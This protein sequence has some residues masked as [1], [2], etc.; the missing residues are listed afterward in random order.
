MSNLPAMR[1]PRRTL[2]V[3][4]AAA[5]VLAGCGTEESPTVGSA[6]E[7]TPTSQSPASEPTASD[8]PSSIT[9]NAPIYF[10][11]KTGGG[12][13]LFREFHEVRGITLTEAARLVD[14]GTPQDPDYRTLWPGGTVVTAVP[15]GPF[16]TVTLN[17]DAFTEAPDGMSPKEADL[18]IQQMVWTLQGVEQNTHRVRFVRPK[19]TSAPATPATPGATVA[20]DTLFGIDISKPFPA[21]DW[22]TTLALVNVTLPTDGASVTGDILE[23]EGLASSFEGNVPWQILREDD[24]VLS[25]F[26]TADGWMEKLYPWSASIDVSKLEP[27][28]YTFVASTDDPSDGESSVKVSNDSKEFTLN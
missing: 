23:A 28:D 6:P 5:F 10:A 4:T 14:G 9:V 3:A 15:E 1:R 13:R 21:A 12:N 2:A 17:A 16:I 25:G 20:P 7:T 18:A 24:V 19:T 27:G 11:G 8:E 26:A 22:T